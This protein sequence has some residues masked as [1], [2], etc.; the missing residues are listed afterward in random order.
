MASKA[1]AEQIEALWQALGLH[2]MYRH[3]D[4]LKFTKGNAP[5]LIGHLEELIRHEAEEYIADLS[6]RLAE[7]KGGGVTWPP[8]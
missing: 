1:Q 7:D 6:Q 4:M 3:V 2:K 8:K 5:Y